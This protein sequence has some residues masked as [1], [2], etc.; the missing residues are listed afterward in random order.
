VKHPCKYCNF[1]AV[2]EACYT[3]KHVR[4][5]HPDEYEKEFANQKAPYH[6]T[7]KQNVTQEER[8]NNERDADNLK[9]GK[10]P[11]EDCSDS[12]QD[13]KVQGIKE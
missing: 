10:D 11:V 1:K 6:T 13:E 7:L 12:L 9:D 4:I 3:K 2:E 8:L 5:K